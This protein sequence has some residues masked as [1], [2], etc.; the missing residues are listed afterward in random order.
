MPA[1]LL[2]TIVRSLD[3]TSLNGDESAET[4]KALAESANGGIAGTKVATV[5]TYSRFAELLK[6]KLIP[7]IRVSA[8]YPG[9]PSGKG[10]K[11]EM[12][13]F[14]RNVAFIDEV[15]LVVQPSLAQSENWKAYGDCI[16]VVRLAV[17]SKVL[18][19]ILE[20]GE[21]SAGQIERAAEIVANSGAD[22]IKTSTG[23]TKRGFT[24]EAFHILCSVVRKHFEKTG[25]RLGLK[26][27]GGIKTYGQAVEIAGIVSTELG[28]DWLVP[29][30]FRIG[31]SSLYTE[32]NKYEASH[33]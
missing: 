22:F 31:A 23:K 30:T 28:N 29:E 1:S 12:E 11:K 26:A 13:E 27:S 25:K 2:N 16:T 18:K 5:C 4:I 32:L 20:T 10:N 6:K 8:V 17:P 15:E 21:L 9:F 3:L 33:Q 14:T 24:T 19:V 7:E